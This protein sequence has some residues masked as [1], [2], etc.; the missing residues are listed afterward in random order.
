MPIAVDPANPEWQQQVDGASVVWV[1]L[2]RAKPS[3]TEMDRIQQGL[4]QHNFSVR[5]VTFYPGVTVMKFSSK[6]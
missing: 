2:Y 6:P 4:A 1:V 5:L 3:D